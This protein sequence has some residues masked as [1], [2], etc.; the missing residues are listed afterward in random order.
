MNGMPNNMAGGIRPGGGGYMQSNGGP[1]PNGVGPS[2]HPMQGGPGPSPGQQHQ[3]GASPMG[4]SMPVGGPQQQQQPNGIIPGP[5]QTPQP[6]L[7]QNPPGYGPRLPG[8]MNAAQQQRGPFQSPTM[9]HSPQG[10]IGAQQSQQQPPGQQQQQPPMGQLGPSPNMAPMNRG[11]ML[12]PNGGM[13]PGQ[14]QPQGGG[15]PTPGYQQGQ[16]GHGV[17]SPSRANTP[18]MQQH[19]SSPLMPPRQPPPGSENEEL[20]KITPQMLAQLKQDLNIPKEVNV[21]MLP[22]N[23]KVRLRICVFIFFYR[24]D[25]TIATYIGTIPSTCRNRTSESAET[26]G[27]TG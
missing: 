19:G 11:G 4:F 12:P 25:W 26:W 18:M 22:L 17:R 24:T 10:G 21:G 13:N 14:P 3:I 1:M 5:P 16:V 9:A 7:G 27:C 23:E 2:S 6:G 15:P 8:P 20:I